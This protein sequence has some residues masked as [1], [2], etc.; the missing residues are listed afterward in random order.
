M[1]SRRLLQTPDRRQFLAGV[2]LAL[3]AGT[4]GGAI[5]FITSI[6]LPWMLGSMII[7]AVGA[8]SG[9]PFKRSM[10]LRRIMLVM[11]G[12]LLGS[13]F[14]ADTFSHLGKWTVLAALVSAYVVAMTGA[15]LSIFRRVGGM[16]LPTAYFSS[17]PGGLGPMTIAGEEAGGDNQLI[18]VSHLIRIFCV[19]ISV[20][21]YLTLSEGLDLTSRSSTISL[22]LDLPQ[23]RDWLIWISCA[24]SGLWCAK[25]MRLP[26]AE[27]LGPM[28][29]SAGVYSLGLVSVPIPGLIT[30]A[31]QIVIGTS[32]G[33]QF[34][35]LRR[36]FL[37]RAIAASIGSTFM[38]LAG[39]IL[40]SHWIGPAVGMDPISLLLALVPGGL[41]EMGLIAVSIDADT[42]FV[43][44][45]H[46]WRIFLIAVSAPL[47]FRFFWRPN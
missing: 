27:V 14:T 33:A 2:L 18:P 7:V 47:L 17:T 24:I 37:L 34:S 36:G 25:A 20:P 31:A 15:S 32:I 28:L 5:F 22:G 39:A 10:P 46:I 3:L 30:I 42:A 6:P 9:A 38:M 21:I 11:M 19:V 44:A 1:G 4:I 35:N 41:V 26:F 8:A 40:L 29:A 23:V 16:N 45:M 12:L 13:F 43:G